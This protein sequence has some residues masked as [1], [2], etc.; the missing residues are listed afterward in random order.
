LSPEHRKML[1]LRVL[2]AWLVVPL[3]RVTLRSLQV[4]IGYDSPIEE[5]ALNRLRRL[6]LWK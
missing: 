3:T 1:N 6:G 2:P 5:G 4:I